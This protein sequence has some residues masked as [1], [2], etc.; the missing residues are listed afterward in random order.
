MAIAPSTGQV[1][2]SLTA[3]VTAGLASGRYVYD[4]E[5]TTGSTVSRVLEGLVTVSPE[6]TK[7]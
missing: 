3:T 2:L 7:A 6:V 5:L 4:V 1:T